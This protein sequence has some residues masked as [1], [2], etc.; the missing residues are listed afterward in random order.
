MSS[1]TQKQ[2]GLNF[3]SRAIFFKHEEDLNNPK[4]H[5]PAGFKSG[6]GFNSYKILLYRGIL[7]AVRVP[8][9]PRAERAGIISERMRK[10]FN[11]ICVRK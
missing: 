8:I 4:D 6:I 3:S 11:S 1:I 9:K 7:I 2:S 10:R 5:D